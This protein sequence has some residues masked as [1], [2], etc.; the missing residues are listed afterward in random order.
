MQFSV[1]AESFI[2]N[3]ILIIYSKPNYFLL[4][5]S[6]NYNLMGHA[7]RIPVLGLGFS[8]D[9][10]LKVA[11]FGISSIASIVGDMLADW[12][13]EEISRRESGE[14]YI[15]TKRNRIVVRNVSQ[16]T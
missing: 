11:R 1:L 16:L 13:D 10:T 2:L 7:F 5:H 8:V 4:C 12:N 14:A 15:L 3:V 6:N 9:T